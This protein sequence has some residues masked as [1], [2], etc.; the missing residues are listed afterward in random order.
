MPTQAVKRTALAEAK[1]IVLKEY[2]KAFAAK[3][4]GSYRVFSGEKFPLFLATGEIAAE[5]WET[6]AVEVRYANGEID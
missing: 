4:G 3:A 1:R 5:A 2:P 6:A